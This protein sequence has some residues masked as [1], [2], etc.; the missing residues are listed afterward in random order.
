M[1]GVISAIKDEGKNLL[2]EA[3]NQLSEFNPFKT[4]ESN[5]SPQ[6]KDGIFRPQAIETAPPV[7]PAFTMPYREKPRQQLPRRMANSSSFKSPRRV[8]KVGSLKP[9]GHKLAKAR[10]EL[11]KRAA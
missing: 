5:T 4:P 9:K 8:R 7:M 6:G 11:G 2:D 1:P 10:Q 3:G